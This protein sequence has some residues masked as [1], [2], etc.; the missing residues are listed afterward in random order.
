MAQYIKYL[1]KFY[2]IKKLFNL[3][4]S[5][6]HYLKTIILPFLFKTNKL[7]GFFSDGFTVLH[8][9]SVGRQRPCPGAML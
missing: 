2:V 3:L 7:T 8:S 9:A 6:F 4:I 5:P 1:I